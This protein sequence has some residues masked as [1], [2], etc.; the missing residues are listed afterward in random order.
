MSQSYSVVTFAYN[1]AKTIRETIK[2]ILANCDRRITKFTVVA[3]G[4]TDRTVE[5]ASAAL[6]GAA[7]PCEVVELALGDKCN[8]WNQYIYHHLP[9]ADVH[10]F[11]DSDVIFTEQ[12]FPRLF[13]QLVS[14]PEK[15]AVTGLPQT[16]RNLSQYLELATR[17]SCLFGNLYGLNDEFLE[18]LI[19]Q[20]IQLPVGLSWIDAQITKLVNDNLEYNKDDYQHRVTFVE[21]VGYRFESLKP[22]NPDDIRLYI[23]RICRYKAGQMQ[24]AYLDA[25]PFVDWPKDL[26]EINEKILKEGNQKKHDI[27]TWILMPL[28]KKRLKKPVGK[29]L[30]PQAKKG[31]K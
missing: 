13:D 23:N 2:S 20:N 6:E 1:E 5:V 27:R 9:K 10:F 25:M 21:G 4:C 12:A 26:N 7:I 22:W 24:E 15:N 3:N 8:A 31:Q 16:G 17:Y 19:K 11:V 28:I 18:R 29:G 14:T 30:K